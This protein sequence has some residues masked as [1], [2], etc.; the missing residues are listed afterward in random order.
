MITII[1]GRVLNSIDK[2]ARGFLAWQEG[3]QDPS[4]AVI[5]LNSCIAEN[6]SDS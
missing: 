5:T 4:A 1:S 3:T 2:P 6:F